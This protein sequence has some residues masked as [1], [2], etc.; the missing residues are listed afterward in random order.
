MSTEIANKAASAALAATGLVAGLANVSKSAPT[1]GG[2]PILKVGKDRIWRYG[3]GDVEL[4][5]GSIWAVNPLTIKHGYVCFASDESSLSGLLG[6]ELVPMNEA[7]PDPSGLATYDKSSWKSCIAIEMRCT[8]GEDEGVEVVYKPSSVSGVDAAAKL[9][10]AVVEHIGVEPSELV[11][12]VTFDA[13]SYKHKKHGIIVTPEINVEGW[14]TLEALET[15]TEAEPEKRAAITK[16]PE[17]E[18]PAATKAKPRTRARA[19]AAPA[20]DVVD[21]EV[22][23]EEPAAAEVDEGPKPTARRRRP[24]AA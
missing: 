7:K 19:K 4:Q 20:E 23:E 14:T 13:D 5:E 1:V 18:K 21:A 22:V 12:L 3:S 24:A 6:E 10:D 2:L 8:N 11:A 9:I 16:E 17:A 15:E